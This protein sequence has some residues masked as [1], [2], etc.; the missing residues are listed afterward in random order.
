MIDKL[1]GI[2]IFIIFIGPMVFFHELGHFLFARLFGIKVEV[3]SIGFGPKILKWVRS[4]TEYCVSAIPL[5]G[6]VKMFGDDPLMHDELTEEEKAISFNGKGKW[7]RFWVVFG[8]PLS[9]FIM[10]YCIFFFLLLSGEKVPSMKVGLLPSS[11]VFYSKGLRS[12]DELLKINNEEV[13]SATSLMGGYDLV[14]DITIQRGEAQQI[15]ELNMSIEEFAHIFSLFRPLRSPNLIDGK[16]QVFE[17]TIEGESRKLSLDE[18]SVHSSSKVLL[19]TS[20]ENKTAP[21]RLEVSEKIA[22]DS[23]FSFLRQKGFYPKD[24]AIKT[25][26]SDYPAAKAGIFG[27]DIILSFEGEDVYFFE[28]LKEKL[29]K[30]TS[31]VKIDVLQ[32]GEVKSFDLM[33]EK[34]SENG[35]ERK[36]IGVLSAADY[37]PMEHR[38]ISGKGIGAS[39][40]MAFNRTYAGILQSLMGFKK[41]IFGQASFKNVGGPLAIGKVA[42]DSFEMSLSSFFRFMA[43]V[44]LGLGVIN[45]FPIPVLDGG[46]I[47]F[48]I[49]E[50]L[51]RGP[52]SR[53][54]MEIAQQ[55]GLSLLLILMLGA[56]F[57]DVSRYLFS[58]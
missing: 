13:F 11:S 27:G 35:I 1:Q 36:I 42:N 48:I 21:L 29:Q 7:A 47:F 12:G 53:R 44:S 56:I 43:I 33:P 8:G 9:N 32:K 17:V 10:A 50:V 40:L 20:L 54:K 41:L 37:L 39:F 38:Y 25:V 28:N 26:S 16:G 4:G 46:H 15:F 34:V 31:S 57:N 52:I 24:M 19:L 23:L 58:M 51:N 18:I 22:G 5:G 30:T 55:V 49:L 45:L 6:Y 3:F 2:F 14:K